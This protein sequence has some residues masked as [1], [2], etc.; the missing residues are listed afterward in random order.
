MY[1]IKKYYFC[2]F[3][4]YCDLVQKRLESNLAT[5]GRCAELLPS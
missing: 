3:W 2:A 5:E 4:T 1:I